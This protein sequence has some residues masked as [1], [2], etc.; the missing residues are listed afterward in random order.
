MNITYILFHIRTKQCEKAEC[1]RWE[2]LE[3]QTKAKPEPSPSPKPNPEA[4]AATSPAGSASRSIQFGT[5]K[6]SQQ[7]SPRS[8]PESIVQEGEVSPEKL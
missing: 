1:E 4:S 5:P 8:T 2:E 7:F 6:S 3:K